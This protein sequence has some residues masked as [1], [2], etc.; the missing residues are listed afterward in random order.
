MARIVH[1][2]ALGVWGGGA[3]FCGALAWR[4]DVVIPS[5]HI[6]DAL[7]RDMRSILDA[8]VLAAAPILL[9]SLLLGWAHLR[10]PLGR[11]ALGILLSVAISGVSRRWAAPEQE[12]LMA[13][14][15]TRIEALDPALPEVAALLQLERV[16]H[17]FLILQG[18]LAFA[19]L[20]A[21]L[22][23]REPRQRLGIQL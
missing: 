6:A 17:A 12:A 4:A 16:G 7:L 23:E 9:A 15:G 3:A 22:R 14:L 21:A 19:L 11:R 2:A 13:S 10:V 20:I 18:G 5:A 8:S 1:I